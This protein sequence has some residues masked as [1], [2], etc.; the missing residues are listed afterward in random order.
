MSKILVKFAYSYES[1]KSSNKDV[2]DMK[3]EEGAAVPI[4]LMAKWGVH[5]HLLW[6]GHRVKY[7]VDYWI[8]TQKKGS[9]WVRIVQFQP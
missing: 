1:C 2:R 7:K 4:K 6:G 5:R 3:D 8:I 9:I